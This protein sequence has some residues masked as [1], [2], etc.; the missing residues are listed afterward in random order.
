MEALNRKST[1][2]AWRESITSPVLTKEEV[3][4]KAKETIADIKKFLKGKKTA[5]AYSGGK[6]SVVLKHLVDRA[7]KE[8]QTFIVLSN[9]E[10]PS[11]EEWL[12]PHIEAGLSV[13]RREIKS[14]WLAQ[15]EHM[16]F[17]RKANDKAKWYQ[18]IQHRGQS[19]YAKAND[20]EVM[21][22]GRRKADGNY[23]GRGA[24]YYQ[25]KSE[26]FI[27]YSPIADWSHEET[28]AYIHYHNIDLP[29][30]YKFPNGFINGTHPFPARPNTKD[31]EQA[32]N[33]LWEIDKTLIE[34]LSNVKESAKMYMKAR[35]NK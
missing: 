22:L 19:Q 7:T 14:E 3:E 31:D 10:Y 20:I 18:M 35:M 11:F 25:K 28:M 17:P 4:N 23:V 9:M 5:V 1:E 27:R 12:K 26:S 33:E 15:N 8:T 32:Y 24:N 21:V 29:P 2:E 30:I 34:R 16:V 13:V 6:D